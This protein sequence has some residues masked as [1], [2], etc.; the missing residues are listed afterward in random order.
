M[1]RSDPVKSMRIVTISALGRFVPY[2]SC[3]RGGPNVI[4]A[5]RVEGRPGRHRS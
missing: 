3:E 2:R 4:V 5:G 1:N